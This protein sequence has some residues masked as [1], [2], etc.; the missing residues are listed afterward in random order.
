MPLLGVSNTNKNKK[1]KLGLAPAN[2]TRFFFFCAHLAVGPF[3]S[4][5]C[6]LCALAATSTGDCNM[7][8]LG[9]LQSCSC[10]LCALAATSTCR[11]PKTRPPMNDTRPPMRWYF[12]A[13]PFNPVNFA[14]GPR[15]ALQWYLQSD[16][17][18]THSNYNWFETPCLRL[19]CTITTMN[20]KHKIMT[21][22]AHNHQQKTE[23]TTRATCNRQ[24]RWH[25]WNHI[26]SNQIKQNQPK[27]RKTIQ[28]IQNQKKHSKTAVHSK[29]PLQLRLLQKDH[30]KS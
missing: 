10:A 12:A 6:A 2:P 13:G 29:G 24:S 27:W 5:S 15:L 23:M 9:Q 8:N 25:I 1:K 28:I 7:F 18:T 14:A 26:K 19:P 30:Q 11:R 16:L 22:N 3:Q 4:C 21:N 20:P 17:K